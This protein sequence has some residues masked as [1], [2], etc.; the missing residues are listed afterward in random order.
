MKKT[1]LALSVLFAFA[2]ANVGLAVVGVVHA[3]SSIPSYEQGYRHLM[4]ALKTR[5]VH[6]CETLQYDGATCYRLNEHDSCAPRRDAAA[7]LAAEW[8]E[9]SLPEETG[10]TCDGCGKSNK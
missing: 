5:S 2:V 4:K 10:A 3:K 1:V 6:T 7:E 9:K 8:I